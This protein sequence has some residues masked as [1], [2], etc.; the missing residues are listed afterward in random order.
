MALLML[1]LF[2]AL[3]ALLPAQVLN[4]SKVTQTQ[5]QWCWAGC[6]QCILEFYG[7]S[8]TQ[9]QIAEYT[10][11]SEQFT[12]I[13]FGNSNC[14]TSPAT[15]NNWNY[16]WGGAGSIEDILMHF[17]S[18]PNDKLSLS[19][20]LAQ[21][22]LAIQANKLFIVRWALTAGGGH[23]VVGHGISGENIY[24]MNPWPGE[25]KK[26]ATHAWLLT[27]TDHS[28]THT[29]ICTVSAQPPGPAGRISGET[30]VCQGG[31]VFTYTIPAIAR[32]LSYE[33][34]LPEGAKGTSNTETIS[35]V[36]GPE[37]V[38]GILTVIGKNNL[39]DGPISGIE[40]TVNP[41]PADAGAITGNPLVC[42]RQ[43]SVTYEVPA[44]AN[45]TSYVWTVN[46]D[47]TGS[48]TTNKITLDFGVISGEGTI[49][50]KGTN[51]CG[52]GEESVL[53][54]K[55]SGIPDTPVISHKG[56]ELTSSSPAGNQWYNSGGTI[57]GATSQTYTITE[58][59]DYYV[60]VTIDGC[61][62][63]PSESITMILNGVEEQQSPAGLMVYPNPVHGELV[64][65]TG[66]SGKAS[67]CT[68][69]GMTGG[70]LFRLV[71]T[72][73]TVVDVG[74]LEP[75]MY[76]L[77]VAGGKRTEYRKFIKER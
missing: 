19:L 43:R 18:I 25:G 1:V 21:I 55:L 5:N 28:W 38:S 22:T 66:G 71:I 51:A 68:I 59:D 33:W 53:G 46:S 44:I 15:C 14:C 42:Q 48:S 8:V 58:S 74:G 57:E 50:V 76:L 62:S 77:R 73:R 36:Y 24:Y 60:V 39:G 29:N 17:A 31:T 12:D 63:D 9:C 6:S 56:N 23:F 35:V 27:A 4:V 20:S 45:A 34:T 69:L 10:R 75:G 16:N 37:A 54:I 30:T 61:I 2:S 64:I 41:M 26:I 70:E 65:D 40:I 52:D 13:G 3:P 72:G 49:R 67:T 32:A 47:A 11:T 7:K